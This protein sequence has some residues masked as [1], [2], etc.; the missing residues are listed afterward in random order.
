MKTATVQAR[1][2]PKLK[3]NVEAILAEIGLSS[4]SAISMYYKSIENYGGIPFEARVFKKNV[5]KAMR[6]AELGRDMTPYENFNALMQD[7]SPKKKKRS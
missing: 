7:L 4:S 5:Q 2:E 6:D 3:K 1:I